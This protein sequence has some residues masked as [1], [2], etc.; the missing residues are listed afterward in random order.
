M[1][2]KPGFLLPLA[3][4]LI[5][6]LSGCGTLRPKTDPA[7]DEMARKAI[8]QIRAT[9]QEIQTSKGLARIRI[10]QENNTQSFRLAWAVASPNRARLILTFA[11][12]PL[13]TITADGHRVRFFSH[14]GEHPEHTVSEPD[15]DLESLLQVPVNLS[16]LVALLLGRIPIPAFDDAWYDR[17]DPATAPIILKKDYARRH[18]KITQ[19]SQGDVDSLRLCNSDGDTEFRIQLSRRKPVKGK[20]IPMEIRMGDMEGRS[21]FLN[22]SKFFVNAPVKERVFWLTP[23]GS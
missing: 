15:P 12:Q 23:G 9:N 1:I 21:L 19:N 17:P 16:D 11:G 5:L 4:T 3:A 13:E 20:Q 2:R 18:W 6:V 8:Q 14:T 10:F 22:I 7:M